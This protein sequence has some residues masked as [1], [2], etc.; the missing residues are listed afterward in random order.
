[1]PE[2]HIVHGDAVRFRAAAL[3]RPVRAASPQGRFADGAATIDG[4][5]LTSAEA[6]GKH[7][8][9]GFGPHTLHVHLGL[10][11]A[12]TWWTPDGEQLAGPRTTTGSGNVRLRLTIP[13]GPVAELRATMV[14]RLLDE[15]EVDTLLA[16]LGPD[17]IREPDPEAAAPLVRR[18]RAP[19]GTLLLDQ[20]VAAG[21]GLIWRCEAPFHARVSPF[22]PGR[23]VTADEWA[24][25]WSALRTLMTAA[26]PDPALDLPTTP[27]P[28]EA[29]PTAARNAPIS[30]RAAAAVAVTATREAPATG[31]RET[32]VGTGGATVGGTD[33]AAVG[34]RD[35]AAVG[36]REAP[37]VG[38]R[39]AAIGTREAAAV[40]CEAVAAAREAV[41]D[42]AREV[43][44]GTREAASG[45]REAVTTNGHSTDALHATFA[46]FRRTGEPCP[47]CGTPITTAPLTGRPTW[48]CPHHQPH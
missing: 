6:Y 46:V 30:T 40:A 10:I 4:R 16:G 36:T 23:D 5:E 3:G 26:V 38:V 35:A 39:D 20:R 31:T 42:G 32:A 29:P 2:G 13:G 33:G 37:A 45:T 41:A 15:A 7:L 22:R 44:V 9:L 19:L 17:P 25:T 14:C 27:A 28:R 48:W 18:S 8:L 24:R 12:W 21:S 1:M 43:P 11:G 47:R 34:A